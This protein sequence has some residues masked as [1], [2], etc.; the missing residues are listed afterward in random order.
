MKYRDFTAITEVM[1]NKAASIHYTLTASRLAV[2]P[3]AKAKK[4]HHKF[5]EVELGR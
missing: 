2:L 1:S 3:L 5:E 4:S